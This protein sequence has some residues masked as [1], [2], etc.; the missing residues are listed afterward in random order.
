MS[1]IPEVFPSL[2]RWREPNAYSRQDLS[3]VRRIGFL[4]LLMTPSLLLITSAANRNFSKGH[5]ILASI[6]AVIGILTFIRVWFGPGDVVCLKEDCITKAISRPARRSSY[7]NIE[8]CSV[9]HCTY[10][11]IKFSILKFT[12]KKEGGRLPI[13]EVQQVA[14]PND[15][16]LERVLQILRNKGVK[17]VEVPLSS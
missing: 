10:N 9:N 1:F 13:G 6:F 5:L 3:L 2:M 16:N 7:K 15:V 17:V 14:V 8:F 4:A 12:F 11:E